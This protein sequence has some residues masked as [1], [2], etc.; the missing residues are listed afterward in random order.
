M[1]G[2]VTPTNTTRQSP[3]VPSR[4][5]YTGTKINQLVAFQQSL[6]KPKRRRGIEARRS[7][8]PPQPQKDLSIRAVAITFRRSCPPLT[9][10][11]LVS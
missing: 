4:I 3:K 9:L 7:H 5:S 10:L 8:S 6:A 11:W 2:R 1:N